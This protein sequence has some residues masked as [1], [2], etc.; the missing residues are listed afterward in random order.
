MLLYKTPSRK[1][2]EVFLYTGFVLFCL[3]V[4]LPFM[5]VIALSLSSKK[6]YYEGK[7][8]FWPVDWYTK[9]Y[10][11]ILTSKVFLTSLRNTTTIMVVN[12]SL[13]MFISLCAG[14]ALANKNFVG[15]KLAFIYLLIP[16]YFSGGLIPYY[17]VVNGYGL[18]NRLG[19]LIFPHLVPIFYIIVFRNAIARLPKEV[20]ESAELDGAS[21]FTTLFRIVAP[22]I[23][24]MVMAFTIFSAV[25]YWN[26]WFDVLIFIRDKWK[27][28]LQYM[29]RD[30]YTNPGIGAGPLEG[31]VDDPEQQLLAQNIIMASI[32]CTIAP[33]IVV[34]PFL[35]RYFIHGVMVGAVKG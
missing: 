26:M 5:Q 21:E 28:T 16:M 8:L 34:Y 35:Q 24:P 18:N 4:V 6:A 2:F 30:I 32:I 27:W 11:V 10:A 15:T 22:L 19:A 33:I 23:L 7:V 9:A 17:L 14:Y 12:T 31:A 1:V 3:A 20:M 13:C 25:G 29:L